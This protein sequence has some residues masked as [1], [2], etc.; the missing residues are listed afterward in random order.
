MIH[1]SCFYRGT[2]DDAKRLFQ[3]SSRFACARSHLHLMAAT[4]SGEFNGTIDTDDLLKASLFTPEVVLEV[5]QLDLL[6]KV[7][8]ILDC[9]GYQGSDSPDQLFNGLDGGTKDRLRNHYNRIAAF[10]NSAPGAALSTDGIVEIIRST[11]KEYR[12]YPISIFVDKQGLTAMNVA[13]AAM[14]VIHE[15]HPEWF[16]N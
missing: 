12:R 3:H 6:M 2:P 5:L 15:D 10:D 7:L 16:K 14:A 13:S 8:H 1:N 11:F 4:A 9:G